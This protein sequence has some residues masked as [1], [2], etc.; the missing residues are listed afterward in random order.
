[1]IGEI[2]DLH[3]LETFMVPRLCVLGMMDN[4]AALPP[5]GRCMS[6]GTCGRTEDHVPLHQT[7]NFPDKLCKNHYWYSP[8]ESLW[9]VA[10]I[11]GRLHPVTTRTME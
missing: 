10:A 2:H 6:G 8:P 1:M 7:E 4:L 9:E 3:A 11:A 5:I